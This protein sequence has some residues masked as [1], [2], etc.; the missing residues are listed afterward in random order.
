[1]TNVLGL[2]LTHFPL[3]ATDD[4]H[5]ANAIRMTL[6]D[7]DIPADHK[8]PAN[9]SP[10]ARE[11]WGDDDG[12][13]AAAGH[14]SRLLDGLGRCRKELDEFRPDVLLVWG[15]DQYENFREEVIPS[16]CVLAYQDS[17][18]EA[19]KV[20]NMLNLP[21][22]WDVSPDETFTMSCDQ[23][24]AKEITAGVL[25]N[26][27]DVAYSYEKRKEMPFPHAFANTQ[28]F[29]DWDNVGKRFPYPIVPLAV[30]CYGEHVIARRG[31]FARFA[32]INTGEVLDPPGPSPQRCY[33][34]GRAVAKTVR[35]RG[36]RVALVASSSW[37]HA[38][39]N[40]KAWHLWPDT[41]SDRRFYEAMVAG[42]H[43]VWLSATG[44]EI[45]RDGQHEMLNWF[46]LLGAVSELGLRLE[47]SDFVETEVFNSNKAFAVFK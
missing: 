35:E 27:V 4:A 2:G 17:V 28:V 5:M 44:K 10:L 3:L 34:F 38:F 14:R 13:S 36:E 22:A 41:A 12:V 43:D 47:W 18:V 45:I 26:G 40:D 33:E 19:F 31:G 15:D 11:E 6:R 9:W 20:L 24:L 25:A 21:N 16:F 29:L 23:E 32:E 7:P 46:C 37:S 39:L 30:N 8:D 1:M 42:D